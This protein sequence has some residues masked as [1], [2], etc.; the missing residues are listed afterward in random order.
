MLY[1]DGVEKKATP[2]HEIFFI[3]LTKVPWLPFG[4]VT[5][6]LCDIW[7]VAIWHLLKLQIFLAFKE[8]IPQY[9]KISS[10]IST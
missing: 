4:D 2:I 6:S 10:K 7:N 3:K 5:K 1:F 8:D 9:W